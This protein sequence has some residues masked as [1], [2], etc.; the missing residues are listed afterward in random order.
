MVGIPTARKS[1]VG[2]SD[3]DRMP[4]FTHAAVFLFIGAI[5]L[6]LVG[7]PPIDLHGLL[8]YVGIMD[9]F[10]GGTRAMYLLTT[11]DVAGAAHYNPIVSPLA[12][13]VVL[14]LARAAIGWTTRRWIDMTLTRTGRR[15]LLAA[16]LLGV[17]ALGVRQQLYADMLMRSWL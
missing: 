2:W 8:H 16:L 9:P 14:L 3:H 10:C 17:V 4:S 5:T 6:G 7:V 11:G 1:S 15:L 12:A 13:S